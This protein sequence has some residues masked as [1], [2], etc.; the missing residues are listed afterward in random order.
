MKAVEFD[1]S[2]PDQLM[3]FTFFDDDG[4][5]DFDLIGEAE[6]KVEMLITHANI[7]DEWC[8]QLI[9]PE[10]E[11]DQRGGVAVHVTIVA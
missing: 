6:V 1:Y 9:H 2:S 8:Q 11:G 5:G 7:G 10:K 3:K 4:G